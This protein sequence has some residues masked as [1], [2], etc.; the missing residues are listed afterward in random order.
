MLGPLVSG[1]ANETK[2]DCD[3]VIAPPFPYL[4]A[5]FPLAGNLVH[6]AG[7]N[8]S[9]QDNGAFTGEV[10]AAMLADIGAK[11][12]ILGHS[13]RRHVYGESSAL[14]GKKTARALAAGVGVIACVGEKLEER[15]AGR[16]A[17]VVT[18][19]M[20]AFAQNIKSWAQVVVAYEPVWAI[21]TGKVATP[22]QAQETHNAI[23]DWLDK[24]VSKEVA[25]ST[26][27]IYGG[28]VKGANAPDLIGQPDVD[29][30]LVG[31]ASLV[32]A[33]FVAIIH[34]TLSGRRSSL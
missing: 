30:F 3:V 12:V 2:G 27:I 8:C 21:G 26:R 17:A 20:E 15:E 1:I 6:I 7:Q 19:Q 4:S 29:G 31:G 18:E 5:A 24:Y 25:Q 32:L 13:E 11:W 33:D 14:I 9:D 16:T 28:S 34:A 10:S 22:L 23:R